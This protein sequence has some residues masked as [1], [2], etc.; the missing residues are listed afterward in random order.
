MEGESCGEGGGEEEEEEEECEEHCRGLL[1]CL[2]RRKLSVLGWRMVYLRDL[3][4]VP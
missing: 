3:F 2:F 1:R 4:E